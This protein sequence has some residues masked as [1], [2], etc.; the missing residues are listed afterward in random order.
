[1]RINLNNIRPLKIRPYT[2]AEIEAIYEAIGVDFSN[3]IPNENGWIICRS[4]LRVDNA[5]SFGIQVD[6]GNWI[7]H[8][9]GDT[10]N[11]ESA[12]KMYYD[13]DGN[14]LTEV[15]DRI[16]DIVKHY[17]NNLNAT[18]SVTT[19][20]PPSAS[21]NQQS[22]S[23]E[24]KCNTTDEQPFNYWKDSERTELIIA[25]DRLESESTNDVIQQIQTHDAVD[26]ATLKKFN[27]GIYNFNGCD[28]L[29]MPYDSGG[30]LYRRN[31]ST[32]DKVIRNLLNS[33][34]NKSFFGS[35]F[36]KGTDRL[37]LCK[38]PRETMLL[39]QYVEDDCIGICGGENSDLSNL[40]K[41]FLYTQFKQGCKEVL[42]YFDCDTQEALE[43][44]RDIAESIKRI[45]ASI[46]VRLVNIHDI[47]DGQ[48]KDLADWVR[49]GGSL[50][51]LLDA[52]LEEIIS[53]G[54]KQEDENQIKRTS[55]TFSEEVKEKLQ[56]ASINIDHAELI[57]F[58]E[59]SEKGRFSIHHK[60]FLETLE[61]NGF[62][63]IYFGPEPV[64]VRKQENIL[65]ES[66]QSKLNDFVRSMIEKLPTDRL[67]HND[68]EDYRDEILNAYYK[69]S[70][71]LT[72][73]TSQLLF[74][75]QQPKF[76]TDEKLSGYLYYK[77]GVV[78][79]TADQAEIISY[80]D[81]DGVIWKDQIIDRKISIDE[82]Q[83]SIS[84]FSQFIHKLGQE[85]DERLN[86]LISS[87]GYLAHTY[88]DKSNTKAIILV[89]E[90]IVESGEEAHGGTGK[91]LLLKSLSHIRK[92]RYI[93]GK[94][95]QPSHR[96]AFQGV[97]LG[98][99]ILL[100]DDVRSNFDFEGL[101]NIITDDMTIE[102]KHQNQIT[103]PFRLSPKIAITT[104]TSVPGSGN[105]YH[106][107]QNIVELPDYFGIDWTVVDEFGHTF[108]DDWDANEWCRFDNFM[109][110]CL[111]FYLKNGL[112]SFLGNYKRKKLIIETS[113]E[114]VEFYEHNVNKDV[115]YDKKDLYNQYCNFIGNQPH[116]GN[117]ISQAVFTIQ[118]K[119]CGEADEN[120]LSVEERK[121]G[122]DR[123]IEFVS[124]KNQPDLF[125]L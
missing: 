4:P 46:R 119:K 78:R 81:L 38:S 123:Y 111:Q 65:T 114:L 84:V 2:R 18:D 48:C 57:P 54:V 56:G 76:L 86:A 61:A 6:T 121:S 28:Y 106:R 122:D 31:T 102:Q 124:K 101:F 112:S 67:R 108:F 53:S 92:F 117:Q 91:S 49:G 30:Q 93:Q 51:E 24:F 17:R 110:S 58:W 72:G 103:L 11:I 1:M 71:S 62:M 80:S 90:K 69:K 10:G 104:N 63:K 52:E 98:D 94:N 20:S 99:Q 118:I 47:S 125:D 22:Y 109:I 8:G 26:L 115:K 68:P 12:V 25:N 41:D 59:M 60:R 50:S 87:L 96:F 14:Q 85:N 36:I 16:W 32:G 113:M 45:H 88:K 79:V 34:V 89:D 95:F 42:V 75:D 35:N 82:D 97:R 120:V 9:T 64:T 66:N 27:C 15:Y 39:S 19:Y 40:Q 70:T 100:M 74:K 29:L 37:H 7:D 43:N 21:G 55:R 5:P 116:S 44:A 105:S 83:A 73:D 13:Y 77:N 23:P 3:K 33:K 107:R